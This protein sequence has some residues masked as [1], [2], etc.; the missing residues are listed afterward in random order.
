M[1]A[2]PQKFLPSS[3]SSSDS[4]AVSSMTSVPLNRFRPLTSSVFL[5]STSYFLSRP[6]GLTLVLP[7]MVILSVSLLTNQILKVRKA[8][9]SVMV[10]CWVTL[11]SWFLAAVVGGNSREAK[12]LWP[13]R[14]SRYMSP[15]KPS[16][17]AWM[18][19]SVVM[20]ELTSMRKES[21]SVSRM[22]TPWMSSLAASILSCAMLGTPTKMLGHKSA[23]G[24]GKGHASSGQD[25]TY[26]R[27]TT[28]TTMQQKA[29]RYAHQNF[30]Q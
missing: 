2:S 23:W 6:L 19:P 11:T 8:S 14:S 29:M 28:R 20:V 17:S 24:G 18:L 10:T 16:T 27:H 15:T 3:S 9:M 1:L 30:L 21:G 5:K 25:G 26:T 4:S 7:S 12:G 22:F 13:S